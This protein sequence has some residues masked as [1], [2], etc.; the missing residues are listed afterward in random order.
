LKHLCKNNESITLYKFKKLEKPESTR[1]KNDLAVIFLDVETTGL[2]FSRDQVI[3]LCI[4][5]VLFNSENYSVSAIAKSLVFHQDPGHPLSEEIKKLTN[6]EDSQL[7]NQKIDWGWVYETIQRA[8]FV[9]CHNAKFDRGMVEGEFKRAGL[10]SSDLDTIW[11]CS[12]DQIF[13]KDFCRPSRSL[14]VLCAWSG[15]FYDSHQADNDVDALVH[16]LRVNNKI[17]ELLEN[18]IKSDYRVF[19]ANSPRNMNEDLK[20]RKYRWDPAVTCWYKS[21]NDELSATEEKKWLLEQNNQIS[22]ELFEI[23]PKH[24]YSSE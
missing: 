9:V 12:M 4:R 5:P 17:E 8:D 1:N 19:A 6:I 2:D 11:A 23:E 16:L 15:F 20:K 21:F 3:Q 22:A 7:S 10:V 14:E 18:A 13:W 24:R